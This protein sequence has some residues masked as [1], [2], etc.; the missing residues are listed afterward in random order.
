MLFGEFVWKNCRSMS[1]EYT[2]HRLGG[3]YRS[4]SADTAQ[5]YVRPEAFHWRK[6]LGQYTWTLRERET[7]VLIEYGGGEQ[8]VVAKNSFGVRNWAR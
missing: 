8:V 3:N 6:C 2:P 7:T 5:N 4:K 1:G